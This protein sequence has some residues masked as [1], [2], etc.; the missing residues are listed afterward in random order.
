MAPH[1]AFFAGETLLY[2]VFAQGWTPMRGAGVLAAAVLG[3]VSAVHSI[4]GFITGPRPSDVPVVRLLTL[5]C[6]GMVALAATW[7]GTLRQSQRWA[8]L[9]ALTYPLY[10][11]HARIGQLLFARWQE[12][13]SPAGAVLA[14][15]TVVY[16]A[17]WSM[18]RAVEGRVVPWLSRQRFIAA[19]EGTRPDP[20]PARAP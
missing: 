19:L 3:Q 17:A 1:G 8:A 18:A 10:L 20:V 11:I 9:G 6:F 12:V 15:I 2:V 16:A 7:P 14:V 13:L 5:A 4:P